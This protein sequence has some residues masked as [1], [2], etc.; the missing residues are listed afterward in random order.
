MRAAIVYYKDKHE[1]LLRNLSEALA[2]GLEEQGLTVDILDAKTM[3]SKLAV[4]KF[5]AFGTEST[6]TFGGKLPE[7]FTEFLKSSGAMISTRTFAF[8]LKKGFNPDKSLLSLMSVMENEG[9]FVVSS[10]VFSKADEAIKAGKAIN[11]KSGL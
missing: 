8:V 3:M 5:I 11:V 9:L 2:K 6:G 1:K 7:G 4:Y 10:E